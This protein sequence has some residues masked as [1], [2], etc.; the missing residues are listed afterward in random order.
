LIKYTTVYHVTPTKNVKSIL[1]KGLKSSGSIGTKPTY[2]E[3][4]KELSIDW[5]KS[6]LWFEKSKKSVLGW[7]S[8]DMCD[9]EDWT[10]LKVRIP[11]K[12]VSRTDVGGGF[13]LEGISIL[14]GNIKVVKR[15]KVFD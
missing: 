11:S 1:S 4:Y 3:Y 12:L 15:V 6:L 8:E 10:I 5:P 14:P 13:A 2:K 7:I 9:C